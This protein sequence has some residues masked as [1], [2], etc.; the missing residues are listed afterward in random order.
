MIPRR[1]WWPRD[2]AMSVSVGL[3]DV[4]TV[5]A[6]VG[7]ALT[8]ALGTFWEILFRLPPPMQ[9]RKSRWRSRSRSWSAAPW[10]RRSVG[11]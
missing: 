4:A 1:T 11:V 8:Q 5:L 2:I 10:A 3:P 9:S 7:H 6:D